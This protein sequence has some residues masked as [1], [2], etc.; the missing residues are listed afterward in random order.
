[1]L[2]TIKQ[3][4]EKI[5]TISKKTIVSWMLL[6]SALNANAI[7]EIHTDV[8]LNKTEELHKIILDF[9]WQEIFLTDLCW[10]DYFEI[11]W[12]ETVQNSFY[13]QL[14]KKYPKWV[15]FVVLKNWQK[16]VYFQFNTKDVKEFINAKNTRMKKILAEIDSLNINDLKEDFYTFETKEEETLAKIYYYIVNN[17]EYCQQCIWFEWSNWINMMNKKTWTCAAYAKCFYYIA[18]EYWINVNY[19]SWRIIFDN[20]Q[21]DRH[22]WNSYNINWKKYFFDTTNETILWEMKKFWNTNF[23]KVPEEIWNL[24]YCWEFDLDVA[25]IHQKLQDQIKYAITHKEE[26]KASRN[27]TPNFI[28]FVSRYK[29]ITH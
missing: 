23:F 29:R 28:H 6:F 1:M 10:K 22:A 4:F 2:E 20:K 17:F 21:I 25:K 5:N 18:K 7:K 19:E 24:I 8:N 26:I 15:D 9:D 13:N 14:M 11:D 12:N 27:I 16:A 3:S